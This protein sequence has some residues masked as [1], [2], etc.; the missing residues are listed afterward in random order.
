MIRQVFILIL[1]L[2]TSLNAVAS[3]FDSLAPGET[4]QCFNVLN[5]IRTLEHRA[6]ISP[7]FTQDDLP[8]ANDCNFDE[9][10]DS[11][12]SDERPSSSHYYSCHCGH[13]DSIPSKSY[14]LNAVQAQEYIFYS[15]EQFSLTWAIS[16]LIRPP[17]IHLSVLS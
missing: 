11:S 16:G 17:Q 9:D 8:N 3:S 1:I 13:F 4:P 15:E 12:E 6:I 2:I 14:K 5:N 7:A 10:R